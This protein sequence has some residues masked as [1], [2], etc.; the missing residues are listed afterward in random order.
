VLFRSTVGESGTIL[1]TTNGGTNWTSQTSGTTEYLWSVYFPDVNTGYIVGFN[2]TIL[3]TI[4]GGIT[5]TSQTSGT[6]KHLFSVYFTDANTGYIAGNAG[7]ILKTTNG[8]DNWTL[9]TTSYTDYSLVSVCFVN[10][11]TGY[12][13]GATG[14][15]NQWNPDA[16]V[17]LKSISSGTIWT[18]ILNDFV[19]MKSM[20]FVNADTGYIAGNH[21]KMLK[22]TNGG[23][24]WIQQN[25]PSDQDILSINFA[26]A[27]TGY[28][29]AAGNCHILKSVKNG[30]YDWDCQLS[31]PSLNNTLNDIYFADINTGYAVG[32]TG[33]VIKT[34][35][36]GEQW[37]EEQSNKENFSVFP[38]PANKNITIETLLSTKEITL[39]ILNLNG[40]ELIRHNITDT[41]TQID[42][43][44]LTSGLY[45]V[46]MITDKTIEVRKITKE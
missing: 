19:Y 25:I 17:V 12:V 41:K 43:S 34:T 46:K 30:N 29:V 44:N 10:D 27:N 22:T 45:I 35:N 36:G 8:G 42:I 2:G 3:K 23:I 11:K 21:N 40:Q 37:V 14:D 18:R 26:D 20:F 28:A 7:I 5:W 13:L 38:S 32:N 1:K 15:Y 4:N 9:Q 39:I 33:T 16:Y 24:S 31:P 6:N